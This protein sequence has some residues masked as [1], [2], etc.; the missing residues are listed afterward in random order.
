MVWKARTLALLVIVLSAAIATAIFAMPFLTRPTE[1]GATLTITLVNGTESV[2]IVYIMTRFAEN[3]TRVDF[4]IVAVQPGD[5][6]TVKLSLGHEVNDVP[7]EVVFEDQTTLEAS[8][9]TW[10]PSAGAS[11][12]MDYRCPAG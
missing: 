7:L 5:I 4:K 2:H 1:R 6:S 11:D 8:T 3:G 9:R 10:T 12:T